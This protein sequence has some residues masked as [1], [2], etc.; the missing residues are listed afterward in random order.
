[1]RSRPSAADVAAHVRHLRDAGTMSATD[2][3]EVRR[4]LPELEFV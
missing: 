2:E 4:L 1:M 3:A